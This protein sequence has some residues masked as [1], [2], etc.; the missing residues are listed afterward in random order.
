VFR[1]TAVA[2][3]LSARCRGGT[4][5]GGEEHRARRTPGTDGV[6]DQ[7]RVTV[8]AVVGQQ[9]AGV[10]ASSSSSADATV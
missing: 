5:S 2:A 10:A 9:P 4:V 7:V 8:V 1:L 3:T 6:V